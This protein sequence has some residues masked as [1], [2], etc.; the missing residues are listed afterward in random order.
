METL[1]WKTVTFLSINLL[2]EDVS[3]LCLAGRAHLLLHLW[4]GET[5]H[6]E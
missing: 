1:L 3:A 2:L 6:G 5:P 4:D